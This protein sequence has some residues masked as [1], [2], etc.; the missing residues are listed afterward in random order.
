MSR[1]LCIFEYKGNIACKS[2]CITNWCDGIRWKRWNKRRNWYIP[3]K[4]ITGYDSSNI[5]STTLIM[6]L[7]PQVSHTPFWV[8][9]FQNVLKL[10]YSRWPSDAICRHSS[11]STLPWQQGSW[12]P[13][14]AHLGPTGPRWAPCWPH[15]PCYLGLRCVTAPSHYMKLWCY[16]KFHSNSQR[17]EI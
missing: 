14:G 3:T 16:R 6:V 7:I 2:N 10:S 8:S 1:V 17:P 13:H 15:E 9:G 4:R 11:G 5:Y 12:G